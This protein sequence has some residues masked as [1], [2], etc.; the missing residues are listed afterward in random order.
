[1]MTNIT[2][3]IAEIPVLDWLGPDFL[4]FYA[5]SFVIAL[6]WSLVR[7]NRSMRSFDARG[8][9]P[10]ALTDP[11]EIA[12]LAGGA[13]RCGQLAVSRLMQNGTLDWRKGGAFR[14]AGLVTGG[15]KQPMNGIEGALYQGAVSHRDK[16]LPL[17]SVASLVT[18]QLRGIESRLAAMG[19]RPTI[20]EQ[21]GLGLSVVLPLV[22][23]ML[24]GVV[25]IF[26]GLSRE[27]PVTF[28]LVAE[29]V[30]LLVT[31]I[32][33]SNQKRLTPTGE[34]TLE[35]LR[36]NYSP[37]SGT[38]ADALAMS[39]G[40]ALLGPAALAGYAALFPGDFSFQKDLTQLGH[41]GVGT[42]SG[43]CSSGCSGGGGGGCGGGG[44]GGCGGG[45]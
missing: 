20:S 16:G 25:K 17:T 28:L 45:D 10:V 42:S 2:N 41:P 7:K 27:K 21:S 39:I 4:R 11:Y 5:V 24:I 36:Q 37:A 38:A 19:L 31:L 23:L 34:R 30:T 15:N 14:T 32:A 9:H 29:F 8:G 6:V 44:C 18:P 40:V 22:G 13:S 3:T 35:S 33:A 1:M 43:G 26:I 12:F